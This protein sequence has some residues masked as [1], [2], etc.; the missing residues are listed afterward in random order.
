VHGRDG[1][2]YFRLVPRRHLLLQRLLRLLLLPLLALLQEL[3]AGEHRPYVIL[4]GIEKGR[5]EDLLRQCLVP[6]VLRHAALQGCR[7]CLLV[8]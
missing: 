2:V 5:E 6:S 8:G 1:R 4:D 3:K 7:P